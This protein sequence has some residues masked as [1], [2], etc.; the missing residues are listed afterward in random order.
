MFL[1]NKKSIILPEIISFGNEQVEVVH[2][3]KLLGVMI[4]EK[5][6]FK[7]FIKATK[8]SINVKLYSFKKLYYLSRNVKSHFFKAFIQPHFDYCSALTI[9]LNKTQVNSIEKF[10]KVVLFRLLNVKLFGLNYLSQSPLLESY[11]LLP[12]RMRLCSRISIFCHKVINKIILSDF[13][14]NLVFKTNC[15]GLGDCTDKCSRHKEIVSVPDIRTNFGRQS[16]G[17]FLPKLINYIILD[18]YKLN[19]KDF[20][21]FLSNNLFSLCETFI[22]N[23][24]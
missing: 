20:R 16:F 7:D 3:F 2:S 23:F 21:S 10:H 9:Y 1:H 14:N 19:I 22:N 5:L 13:S 18:K 4:D 17:Y 24:F 11:N 8:K 6:D 12:Y 15:C